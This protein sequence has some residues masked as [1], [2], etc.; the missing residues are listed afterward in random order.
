VT[1]GGR[2]ALNLR[3]AHP[4]RY[5][6]QH[7]QHLYPSDQFP[8]AYTQSTD[9]W[10]GQ[11]DAIL[12]RPATDPLIVH[13]QT[14]SEYWQ[15][16]GSLVHTDAYGMDLPDHPHA[17][18][19]FFASSQHRAV[20][21]GPP[22]SGPHQNLSNPLNTS[23]LLRALLDQLDAWATEGIPPTESRVP[24]R[25]NGTL[26]TAETVRQNFPRIDDVETPDEPSRL[27]LQ[28]YGPEFAQGLIANH[29]PRVDAT[30][31]YAVLVPS[32]DADGN[33]IPGLRTPDVRV[34]LATYTGWNLRANGSGTKAMYSIVGSYI[35]FAATEVEREARGDARPA[36]SERYRSKADYVSR[37]ALA[38][39]E[40]V[41]R[42]LLLPEDGDR[43]VEAAIDANI[44]SG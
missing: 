40:L 42:R 25:A 23:T 27:L 6:R 1:G 22:E 39:R 16:R 28:D 31:E 38:V 11:T 37:V 20:P 7:E 34:P 5:P 44:L 9:P 32:I 14:A 29:P 30:Q 2:L 15:R 26:V 33:D 3:F 17:Q 36:L 43:Y 12:K 21:N 13:T 8:F 35:A 10:S 18:I 41:E 24:R 19:F 4:D